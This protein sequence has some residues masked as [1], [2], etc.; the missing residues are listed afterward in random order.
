MLNSLI[1]FKNN[2][3]KKFG[4]ILGYAI[5]IVGGLAVISLLG[6]LLKTLLGV[7][8]GLAVASLVIFGVYKVYE[9]VS[10]KKSS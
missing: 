8:I 10:T 6:L 4:P 5:L 3:V 1:E 9:A 7:L 2:M